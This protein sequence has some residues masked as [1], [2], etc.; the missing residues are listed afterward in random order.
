MR[1]LEEQGVQ[2]DRPSLLRQRSTLAVLASRS[3][4]YQCPDRKA[5][6]HAHIPTDTTAGTPPADPDPSASARHYR[7]PRTLSAFWRHLPTQGALPL[8]R[9]VWRCRWAMSMQG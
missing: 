4:Q 6:M 7:P 2:E 8:G 1:V 9:W 3:I 5:V